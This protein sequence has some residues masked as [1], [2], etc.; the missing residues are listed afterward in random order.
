[1]K[2][3]FTFDIDIYE[4]RVHVLIQA[5]DDEFESYIYSRFDRLRG[6]RLAGSAGCYPVRDKFNKLHYVLDFKKP[7]K[8][9]AYTIDTI[10]HECNHAAFEIMNELSMPYSYG[11]SDETFC[12]LSGYIAGKVYEGIFKKEKQK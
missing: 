12:Y 1:M 10:V 4:S 9:D 5:T 11:V 6:E 7:M 8:T 3:Q 2:R